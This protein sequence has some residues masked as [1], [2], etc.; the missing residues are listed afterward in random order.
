M[1]TRIVIQGY[2]KFRRFSVDP[3]PTMN[4]I[5]GDN[6][7]GKSTLLEAITLA[8][9]G[10]IDGRWANEELN[11]YW[12]NAKDV[13]DYFAAY[14]NNPDSPVPKISIEL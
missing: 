6:E 14:A 9:S 1:I 12:F 2:R 8:L 13:S 4:I 11:P 10:R 3:D 7:A 5:I